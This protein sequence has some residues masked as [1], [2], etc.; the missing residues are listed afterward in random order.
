MITTVHWVG[1]ALFALAILHTFST[2]YFQRLAHE[3]PVHAGFW[4]LLGEV[5]VVFGFW[6][7][8]LVALIIAL[9]G[10]TAAT[11]YLASRDYTEPM[12]VFAIMV[13]AGSRPVLHM[14]RGL[15]MLLAQAVPARGAT[16]LYLV[17]LIFVPLLGSFITE[18]AAMTLAALMLR[19]QIY[20]RNVSEWLKYLTLGVLFVNV[21]I[22]GTLTPFAAPPVLMVAGAFG[23]DLS[24][25]LGHFGWKAAVAVVVGTVAVAGL[26]RRQL[27]GTV[28]ERK[29]ATSPPWL[30]AAHVL[31]LALI[32]VS[33]HHPPWLIAELVATPQPVIALV[34]GAAAGGGMSLALAA[35]VRLAGKSAS[36]RPSFVQVG[37]SGCE[38]GSSLLCRH[39][40]PSNA[41]L[42]L[43][44]GSSIEADDALRLGLVSM[45]VP[46]AQLTEAGLE[47]A[48]RMVK[49]ASP[50]G[51][52]LTKRAV[53]QCEDA[54][55]MRNGMDSVFG[56]HHFAHAHNAEVG[57]DSL[58]GMDAKSMKKSAT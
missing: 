35:D 5:E 30:A 38:L 50:I 6:A 44:T 41:S 7:M 1:G 46:D 57:A 29:I 23:W 13:V 4:H 24:F 2:K 37:L 18:P 10:T 53:N 21:S 39:I 56:L 47:V 49:N 52:A 26:F 15:A 42:C 12:F 36:F 58:G 19:E 8:V 33:A 3:Q 25:M 55:G 9:Q 48:T 32:V 14:A 54:M 51:L 22:G 27:R 45:V 34:H 43:M 28:A 17:T 40:G 11:T 20:S 31:F 16:G